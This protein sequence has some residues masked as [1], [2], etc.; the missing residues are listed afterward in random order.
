MGTLGQALDIVHNLRALRPFRSKDIEGRPF[1]VCAVPQVRVELTEEEYAPYLAAANGKHD[2]YMRHGAPWAKSDLA[3][4]VVSQ[5]TVVAWITYDGER[6]IIERDLPTSALNRARDIAREHLGMNDKAQQEL[7]D[8]CA[9]IEYATAEGLIRA[10]GNYLNRAERGSRFNDFPTDMTVREYFARERAKLQAEAGPDRAGNTPWPSVPNPTVEYSD[11]QRHHWAAEA[12]RYLIALRDRFPDAYAA[13]VTQERHTANRRARMAA[14]GATEW[15]MDLK[16][17]DRLA[18]GE[19]TLVPALVVATTTAGP[20][21][22]RITVRTE[23]GIHREVRAVW[24]DVC[25]VTPLDA[26]LPETRELWGPV[27]E[28][29]EAEGLPHSEN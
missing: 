9:D 20:A 28:D 23:E 16:P 7:A 5:G 2:S 15:L 26:L 4:E 8:D 22:P 1:G 29:L 10:A 25:T 14:C 21:G 6:H 27:W 13:W 19:R 18:V 17:G 24:E 11:E 3:Y 12:A